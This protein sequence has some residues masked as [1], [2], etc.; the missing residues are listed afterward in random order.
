MPEYPLNFKDIPSEIDVSIWEYEE[1]LDFFIKQLPTDWVKP[2]LESKS[3]N[4][5]QI[6]SLAG[7]LLLINY[8]KKKKISPSPLKNSAIGKP[9][10]SAGPFFS[11]SHAQTH[12]ALVISQKSTVGIDIEL[13]HRPT[14]KIIR[15]FL[16]EKELEIFPDQ[17]SQILAWSI[18][19][20][21]YKAHEKKG[22]SFKE[23][24]EIKDSDDRFQVVVKETDT[25][26]VYEIFTFQNDLFAVSV[27]I[28]QLN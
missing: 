11:I 28:P 26:T 16:S 7:R 21:V 4:N 24:I 13:N 9:E 23:G 25:Q 20:A 8:L 6:E 17:K 15:K 27:A 3:N 1:N 2:I 19:E 14:Q 10:L 18:K 22:L 5:K 12:A